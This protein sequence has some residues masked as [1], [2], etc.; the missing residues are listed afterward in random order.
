MLLEEAPGL[1]SDRT[2]V[3]VLKGGARPGRALACC[4]LSFRGSLTGIWEGRNDV[5]LGA[6]AITVEVGEG[7]SLLSVGDGLL[8]SLA[9]DAGDRLLQGV[10]RAVGDGMSPVEGGSDAGGGMWLCWISVGGVDEG[11]APISDGVG[12]G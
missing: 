11:S 7:S 1:L 8:V 4:Q 5:P 9:A 6:W 3:E 2:G 12:L 10:L